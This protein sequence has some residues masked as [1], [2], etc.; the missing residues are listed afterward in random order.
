[1]VPSAEEYLKSYHRESGD[2]LNEAV[3]KVMKEFAKLHVEACKKKILERLR[4]FPNF[5]P[6]FETV[7]IDAYTSNNIK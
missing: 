5:K 7:V 1:M 2:E 3:E 4:P 6:Y